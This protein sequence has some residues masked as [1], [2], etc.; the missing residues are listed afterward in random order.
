[1]SEQKVTIAEMAALVE[2][3]RQRVY[4]AELSSTNVEIAR[5]N[6]AL[7]GMDTT[8]VDRL[9]WEADRNLRLAYREHDA[10]HEAYRRVNNGQV[11]EVVIRRPSDEA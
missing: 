7:A 2:E 8:E 10:L 9:S 11:T 1:M 4:S 3:A 5:A 6:A